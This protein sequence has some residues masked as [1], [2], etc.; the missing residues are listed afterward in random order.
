MSML[1]TILSSSVMQ[2]VPMPFVAA[3][4]A[5]LGGL[6]RHYLETPLPP[7]G[8]ALSLALKG[9]APF[10]AASL[11]PVALCTLGSV[12]LYFAFLFSQVRTRARRARSRTICAVPLAGPRADRCEARVVGPDATQAT[13]GLI[14]HAQL[15]GTAKDG[16]KLPL[17][18]VKYGAPNLIVRTMD[19]SVGNQIEQVRLRCA[20]PR[21]P[22]QP[23]ARFPDACGRRSRPTARGTCMSSARVFAASQWIPFVLC[24][25]L[26][27]LFVDAPGAARLGWLWIGVRSYYPF[28]F[29]YAFKLEALPIVFVSTLPACACAPD[30]LGTLEG[31]SRERGREGGGREGERRDAIRVRSLVYD[32]LTVR[33]LARRASLRARPDHVLHGRLGRARRDARL[34]QQPERR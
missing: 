32:A 19:R 3:A 31:S 17:A 34:N 27:A 30:G 28:A 33:L 9:A 8:P 6:A 10:K 25:W 24:L 1:Q 12:A 2:F 16:K 26:Y 23:G 20:R 5:S 22:S 11:L 13:V 29:Y 15:S 14:A 21:A 18:A 4:L 7:A